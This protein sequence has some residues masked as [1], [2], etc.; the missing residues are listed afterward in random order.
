MVL[1]EGRP[2][3]GDGVL[4]RLAHRRAVARWRR[5]AEAAA[6]LDLEALRTLRGQ[7][8]ALR[9]HLD[10]VLHVA[11]GRLALPAIGGTGLRRPPGADWVWRPD[12]WTGPV[13]IPGRAAVETRTEIA[14]ATTIFH[15]CA[16]SE[17]TVRQIRNTRAR[18]LA[19]FGLTIEVYDFDGS[20]LSVV[21]DLPEAGVTGLRLRHIVRI[22]AIV[23]LEA[24]IEVFAR[25][26][27]KHGPNIEQVVREFP[28]NTREAAVEFDLAYT[29]INEKRVEKAWI[30]LIF[31]GPRMN[32]ITLRDLTLIRRMRAEP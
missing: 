21:L 11:E 5:L 24:P 26:N 29:K 19:P 7:A 3:Q 1:G 8:R 30:D 12:A 4:D 23:E 2:V 27:V 9:R 16:T 15:D 28:R 14:P 32:R 25:L 13:P 31:D 10:R 6:D 18:D 17:I 22:D 20:F